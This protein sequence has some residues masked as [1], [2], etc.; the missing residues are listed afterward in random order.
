[1]VV[2]DGSCLVTF[3]DVCSQAISR[4]CKSRVS[5]F[6]LPV[7][8]RTKVTPSLSDHFNVRL[9][10]ISLNSK[11]SSSLYQIGPSAG[12]APWNGSPMKPYP[13][14]KISTFASADTIDVNSGDN[15]SIG[16][17]KTSTQDLELGSRE[18]SY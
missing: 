8:S 10:P 3:R 11:Y 7:G 13:V 5:P 14:P 15:C 1:M 16:K 12:P 9:C 6:A 17:K 2:P 4:P 18:C